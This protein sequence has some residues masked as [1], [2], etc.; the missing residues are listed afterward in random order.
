LAV[1]Y[2]AKEPKLADAIGTPLR[3]SGTPI[4]RIRGDRT[5]YR[6]TVEG[7]KNSATVN[8][9]FALKKRQ[10]VC[11]YLT[12]QAQGEEIIYLEDF[13]KDLVKELLS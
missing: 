4:E 11:S 3:L 13:D 7:P 5:F 2:L 12:F 8:A 9:I 10:Y 1:A 6:F